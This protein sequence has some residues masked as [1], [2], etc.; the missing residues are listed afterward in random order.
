MSDSKLTLP[1]RNDLIN[2]VTSCIPKYSAKKNLQILK[3]LPIHKQT[4]DKC[5]IPLQL[6]SIKLPTWGSQWGI[7][8][9]ILV[10]RESCGKDKN[11][12]DTDWWLAI[13]MMLECW[14][15]RVWEVLH[16]PIHSYSFRLK[17]WDT[18]VW[19]HAWV[20]RIILF[21]QEWA[22]FKKRTERSSLFGQLPHCR[23]QLSFDVDAISKTI[24]IRVKQGIFNFFNS[25]RLACLLNPILATNRFRKALRFFFGNEN[26]WTF[27]RIFDLTKDI[28]PEPIFNF[29]ASKNIGFKQWLMDPS[30]D[31]ENPKILRLINEIKDRAS[32]IGLHP[33]FDSWNDG[34]ALIKEKERLEKAANIEVKSARQHWLRFSWE[35]TWECQE[36]AG[37]NQDTTLMFNDRLGF[38]NSSAL[39]WNPWNPSSKNK[40]KISSKPTILMDSHLFDYGLLTAPERKNAIK[41]LIRENVSIGGIC[42]VLW[43]PHTLT[44]DYGWQEDFEVLLN[45]LSQLK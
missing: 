26:W 24:P 10:P 30:Y 31:I 39:R 43:H 9:N 35:Q 38:R 20:N 28:E 16:G 34:S 14:H 13:F 1:Q 7:N 40:R 42:S 36:K 8:G 25:I 32:I 37:L 18:R 12:Q 41:K 44:Q 27:E 4:I 3:D 45:E 23:I 19:D 22:A 29:C 15:E 33:S 17:R 6:I 5:E 21:L 11:W 2:H